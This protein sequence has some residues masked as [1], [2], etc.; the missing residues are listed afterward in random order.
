LT[1]HPGHALRSR[2]VTG[3]SGLFSVLFEGQTK[4]SVHAFL[5]A[6][7]YSGMGFSWGGHESLSEPFDVTS[8]G[9]A[10]EWSQDAPASAFTSGSGMSTT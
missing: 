7:A 5:D 9:V 1:D 4:M 2:D 3:A 8:H 10:T 6:L